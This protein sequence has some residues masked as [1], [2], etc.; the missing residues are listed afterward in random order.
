MVTQED[1]KKIPNT[2]IGWLVWL[3]TQPKPIECAD[4]SVYTR[5]LS[6]LGQLHLSYGNNI[7]EL[8]I[9]T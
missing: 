4:V 6:V 9:W 1:I 8:K 7:V 2:D 5:I 3:S